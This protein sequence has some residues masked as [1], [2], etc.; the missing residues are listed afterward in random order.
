MTRSKLLE[1]NRIALRDAEALALGF[2]SKAAL[3][4]RRWR[5]Y[6]RQ[7]RHWWE[8]AKQRRRNIEEL[9]RQS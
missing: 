1:D 3:R 6:D 9:E 2:Q 8:V 5:Y 7:S 4:N